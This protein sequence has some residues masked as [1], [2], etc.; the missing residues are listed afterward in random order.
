MKGTDVCIQ[1]EAHINEAWTD[2]H[3]DNIDKEWMDVCIHPSSNVRTLMSMRKG[4]TLISKGRTFVLTRKGLRLVSRR[5]R[6]RL[7]QR[8]THG[9]SFDNIDEEW[10][11]RG[12][13]CRRRYARSISFV[14][15]GREVRCTL[16]SCMKKIYVSIETR[17]YYSCSALINYVQEIKIIQLIVIVFNVAQTKL[18]VIAQGIRFRAQATSYVPQSFC[19]YHAIRSVIRKWCTYVI[20]NL[21]IRHVRGH[22][23]RHTTSHTAQSTMAETVIALSYVRMTYV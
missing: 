17:I 18:I 7:Y 1:T 5:K 6:R 2:A 22:I 13:V 20:G 16:V 21:V 11:R 9:R 8:G 14:R 19:P 10:I 15:Q 23:S 4:S 3:I 12:M